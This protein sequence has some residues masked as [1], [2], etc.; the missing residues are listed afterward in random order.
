MGGYDCVGIGYVRDVSVPLTQL[1]CES[2]I[3]L[4]YQVL[5]TCGQINIAAENLL[6]YSESK[7]NN[8][9]FF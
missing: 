7:Y 1:C 2:E 6:I 8:F 9:T 3:A 4:K 5:K